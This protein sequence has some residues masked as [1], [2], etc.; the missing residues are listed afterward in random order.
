M[1]EAEGTALNCRYLSA[2]L[3]RPA[4]TWWRKQWRSAIRK[5]YHELKARKSFFLA[6]AITTAL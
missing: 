2:A 6:E 3:L 4:N 1:H 5:E